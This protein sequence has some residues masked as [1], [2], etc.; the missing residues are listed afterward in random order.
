MVSFSGGGDAPSD[1]SGGAG[2]HRRG[3]P[4][5]CPQQAADL[6]AATTVF[7][8]RGFDGASIAE[9]AKRSG[10]PKANVYYYSGRRRRSTPPSSRTLIDEWDNAL[11]HLRADRDPRQRSPTMS[12]PSSISRASMDRP[13]PDVRACATARTFLTRASRGAPHATSIGLVGMLAREI[14]LGPGHSRRGCRGLAIG[15]QMR[16]RIVPLID[17]VRR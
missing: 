17:Q 14:E 5:P 9:I 1:E 12:G 3:P 16:Q 2:G 10:L 15:P 8:R 11:A 13:S 6:A 7:S 4:H